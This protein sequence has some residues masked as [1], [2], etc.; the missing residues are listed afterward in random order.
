MKKVLILNNAYYELESYLYQSKRLKEELELLGAQVTVRKND[1][2][3]C[4]T[5]GKDIVNNCEGYDFCIYLDKDKYIS[6]MLEKSGLRVINSHKAMVTC[7]DKMTTYI[8]LSGSG[9]KT[10]KTMPGLLCYTKDAKIKQSTL[11]EIEKNLGY[12]I[13]VK[14]SF[15]SLGKGVYKADN[16]QELELISRSVMFEPHH[17][18]E[19]ISES[20]GRDLRVIVIGG[21]FVCAMQRKSETDF[22]SNV[23]LGGEGKIVDVPKEFIEVA[24]NTAKVLNLDYCGIDLLYGKDCEPIVCEVNSNAFF[25][26]IERVTGKNVAKAYAKY[27]LSKY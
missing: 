22:R 3:P 14:K 18:Q 27:L 10:P 26:G 23:E 21:K 5:D 25:G 2:F 9:I 6:E 24:E 19:Y 8:A 13:I 11:D 15:G 4:I 7:D 20:A 12:P 17:Y 1:F 16:R